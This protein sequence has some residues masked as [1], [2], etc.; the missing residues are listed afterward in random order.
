MVRVLFEI[1]LP[2]STLPEVR[3]ALAGSALPAGVSG[4]LEVTGTQAGCQSPAR[5]GAAAW[6]PCWVS[7]EADEA[8][9]GALGE[10]L[11][12]LKG[13]LAVATRAGGTELFS[14]PASAQIG[15]GYYRFRDLLDV[16][17]RLG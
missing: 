17:R 16:P 3:A 9:G 7:L 13:V 8:R 6:T 5:G 2:E 4:R 11:G 10:A 15:E 14:V 12:P 1:S